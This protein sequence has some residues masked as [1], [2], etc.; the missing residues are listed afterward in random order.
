VP[1]TVPLALAVSTSLVLAAAYSTTALVDTSGASPFA[2]CT[3][4]NVA[5][6]D[7][8]DQNFPNSEVEPWIDVN[9][10]NPLNIVGGYQQDR[11]S[12]GG[13]RGDVTS[14]SLNGGRTWRQV[15]IPGVTKCEGG[16]FD[17]ATDPWLSFGA[18][19]A[20]SGSSVRHS[21]S[22]TAARGCLSASRSTAG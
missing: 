4:D 9:P 10:T 1:F 7:A 22:S 2:T 5:G 19:T 15:V 17:R 6:Q 8:F 3:A 12:G 13:S 21:T 14:V 16:P 11:W 18:L 20:P